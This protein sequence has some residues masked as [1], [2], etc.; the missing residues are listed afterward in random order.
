MT[1]EICRSGRWPHRPGPCPCH[2]LR[3]GAEL[4]AIAEPDK[5]PPRPHFAP[6]SAA[7]SGPSTRLRRGGDVDAVVICTPTNT[8]ADLIEQFA[9]AGKKVFC[10]KPIDLEWIGSGRRMKSSRPRTGHADGRLPA[11]VRSRF[12][13]AVKKAIDDGRIGDG[14]DGHITS[15][16]PGPP[17]RIHQ[18]LGRYLPGHDDPRFRRR[19]LAARRRGRHGSGR[20]LGARP[21]PRSAGSAITTAST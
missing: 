19:A 14:R 10:E 18:G 7:R 6:P 16:D 5:P 11:P 15:R 3:P 8:H 9:K 12:H 21:T 1:F 4:V 2:R 20:G 13:G 17:P